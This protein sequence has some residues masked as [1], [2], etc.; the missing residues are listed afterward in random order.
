M[1]GSKISATRVLRREMGF[2]GFVI[3]DWNGHAEIPGCTA[4]DCPDALLAGVDM[5]MAPD[6]WKGLYASLLAQ[7]KNGTIPMA[8]LDEA[9]TR[10]LTVKIRAGLFEA[11]LPSAR[12]AVSRKTLG[13]AAHRAVGREAVR[14]SL[15]LLKN[16]DS[17]LPFNPTG[18]IAVVGSA[19]NS[20]AQQ[21]G[22]GPCLGKAT[23]M[24]MRNLKP[25]KQFMPASNQKLRPRAAR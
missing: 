12:A 9:V 20:M 24:T 15:V 22:G 21:T 23:I 14:K 19:A 25:E 3:G 17:L 2:N 7:V 11:G 1:H 4:T 6:S 10:I 5:Y 16:N 18:H 13:S 8:R